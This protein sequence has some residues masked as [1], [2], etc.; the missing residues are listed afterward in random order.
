[1]LFAVLAACTP[2]ANTGASFRDVSAPITSIALFKAADFAGHWDVIAGFGDGLCAYD[3]VASNGAQMNLAEQKCLGG[4][5]HSVA[6]ITGPGRYTPSGG[7]EHWV[8]WV[9]QTYRT[10][11][12]GAVSGEFGMI[13]NR[14][15]DIPADRLA[16]ARE[17]LQWNGYDL[18]RLQ[19]R[20]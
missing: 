8:L 15:R 18:T 20:P 4:A 9:D 19:M 16:A 14:G 17:I 3:V 2:V 13:L 10:A 5:V 1:M 7:V 6:Q 11:V 12:I